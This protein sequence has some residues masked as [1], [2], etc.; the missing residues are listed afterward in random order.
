MLWF[1]RAEGMGGV[2]TLV[3]SMSVANPVVVSGNYVSPGG[4]LYVNT[5]GNNVTWAGPILTQ[6]K[7]WLLS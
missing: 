3:G 2:N 5:S 6:A 1:Q 4:A 7:T